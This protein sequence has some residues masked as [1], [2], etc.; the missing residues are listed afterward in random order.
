[1]PSQTGSTCRNGWTEAI[2][3][4]IGLRT[5]STWCRPLRV[6]QRRT[7]N[8]VSTSCVPESDY[9]GKLRCRHVLPLFGERSKWPRW[10]QIWNSQSLFAADGGWLLSALSTQRENCNT[11]FYIVNGVKYYDIALKRYFVVMEAGLIVNVE[12]YLPIPPNPLSNSNE[13]IF[14]C[15]RK[16]WT[17]F[18]KK[19]KIIIAKYISY[20]KENVTCYL[21]SLFWQKHH[22]R[23]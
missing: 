3:R 12:D 22:E 23:S 11:G 19:P 15:A 17:K 5:S 10:L 16:V 7:Q 6:G 1:M 14:F 18:Q 2:L 20:S 4:T 8:N 21:L 13:I 9:R